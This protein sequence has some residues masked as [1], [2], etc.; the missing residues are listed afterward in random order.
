MIQDIPAR[1]LRSISGRVFL[2]VLVDTNTPPPDPGKLKIGGVPQASARTQ[3]GGQAGG[4]LGQGV[5]KIG[6]AGGQASRQGQ[7]GAGGQSNLSDYNLV[8]MAGIQLSAGYG[9]ATTDDNGNFLLRDLPAGELTITVVPAKPLP[10]DMKVPSGAVRMPPEPIEIRGAT[11][12][13]S[14]PDLVPY[15]VGKT[16]DEVR[17]AAMGIPAPKPSSQ[18]AAQPATTVEPSPAASSRRKL[19]LPSVAPAST[20]EE[21]KEEKAAENHNLGLGSYQSRAVAECL[22]RMTYCL[23]RNNCKSL[24]DSSFESLGLI[25]ITDK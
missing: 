15:L 22:V 12:V 11:I 6:Q 9:V 16:A 2:K 21:A 8:P 13:I 19:E 25:G 7:Q 1:A 18:P 5:G 23:T 24:K 14:N 3:R 10:P 4:K 17:D 20:Q